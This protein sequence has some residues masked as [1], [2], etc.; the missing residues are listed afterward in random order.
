MDGFGY[1]L[2]LPLGDPVEELLSTRADA[3]LRNVRAGVHAPQVLA[4]LLRQLDC[5]VVRQELPS[6]RFQRVP[7]SWRDSLLLL[8]SRPAAC[9][10]T[11]SLPWSLR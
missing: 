4:N 2:A 1:V 8:S 5:Q 7:Q 11:D 6:N 10:V 9:A 3:G